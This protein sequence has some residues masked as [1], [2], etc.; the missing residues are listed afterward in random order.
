LRFCGKS[1]CWSA[2]VLRDAELFFG[3]GAFTTKAGAVQWAHS[4]RSEIERGLFA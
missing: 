2:T 1:Y 4:L 3:H